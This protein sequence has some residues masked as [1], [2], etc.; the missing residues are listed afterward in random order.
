MGWGQRCEVWEPS[1]VTAAPKQFTLWAR[2]FQ[3]VAGSW[4]V[5]QVGLLTAGTLGSGGLLPGMTMR[6]WGLG[7]SDLWEG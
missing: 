3:H 1:L 2:H 7:M 5:V 6:V 4:W